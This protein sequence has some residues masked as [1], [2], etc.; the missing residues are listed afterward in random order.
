MSKFNRPENR[1][2][3]KSP[4]VSTAPARTFE[5]G[6]GFVRD[7]KSEL[8]LLAVTNMVGEETFYESA[9][10]RDSRFR[11]LVGVV[12]CGDPDW[13]VR[14]IP[15]LR[16]DANMRSASLIAACEA[17]K[18]RLDTDRT[19]S[20]ALD[21]K[22]SDDGFNRRFIDLACQRADEP[23]EV[24]AYWTSHYGR[25]IPKP[26]K[27][28][29]GDAVRR[30]Y[31]GKSLIKHDGG[32]HGYRFGDVLELAHVK[33]SADKPWQGDLF[34]Y[35]LDVRHRGNEAVVPESNKTLSLYRELMAIPVDHRRVTLAAADGPAAL[36]DAGM[37]WES[38]AGWLQGPMDKKAW[39]AISPS[40]GYMALLRNLRNFDE[41]GV[42]DGTAT[43]VCARLS[44]PHEV[45]R[46]RQLPFRF[47]SAYRAAPSDRWKW[48]LERALG[49]SL[50]NIPELP[51][52]TLILIDTSGSMGAGFS[53]DGKLA[54]WDA[55]ALFGL[56]VAAR[57]AVADVFSFSSRTI[58]FPQVKGESVLRSLARWQQDGFFQG[59][60]TDTAG[61]LR[62]AYSGHSRVLILTDEQAAWDGIGVGNSIPAHI[63]LFTWNLAGYRVG[64]SPSGTA[65]RH[66][67]GGLNDASFRMVPLLERADGTWPF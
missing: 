11:D 61:S 25:N 8:F 9:A 49:H 16:N 26:V 17:V 57:C 19:L 46:S 50:G 13:M 5:G 41:A 31:S 34:K 14:F 48:A 36:A 3:V 45:A 60:G 55:A 4:V 22:L 38:L 56:A 59:A 40:M 28:G 42:S 58:A 30:L 29:V 64:H 32:S 37:T 10:N 67:F 27:R 18:A 24:L 52:R 47:L 20:A 35:A 62:S 43:A 44:D 65:H 63:P 51:G 12:A 1:P 7:Q 21:R 15:W 66:A 54:R 23:G 2:V 33:P 53:K 6:E 39:E